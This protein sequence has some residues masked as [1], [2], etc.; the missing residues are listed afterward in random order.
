MLTVKDKERPS[1]VE[2]LQHPWFRTKSDTLR[3]VPAAQFR[4][5]EGF[6][7]ETALKRSLRLEIATRLPMAHAERIVKVF[8]SFDTNKDGSLSREELR[9]AFHKMK[10]KDDDL[11]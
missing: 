9:N 11:I 4:P 3:S 1:M 7:K 6:S 2:V 8:K 10:V 5:L